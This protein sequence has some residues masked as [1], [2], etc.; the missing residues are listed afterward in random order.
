[1]LS[2]VSTA[3]NTYHWLFSPW[4]KVSNKV[5]SESSPPPTPHL[6][7]SPPTSTKSAPADLTD[8]LKHSLGSSVPFLKEIFLDF[9]AFL[10]KN[11]WITWTGPP[12]RFFTV[13][14]LE[15]MTV[16]NDVVWSSIP[17]PPPISLARPPNT[18]NTVTIDATAL[19][20]KYHSE[21]LQQQPSQ[22][23]EAIEVE[24]K[25]S[26]ELQ[27]LQT[28]FIL[29]PPLVLTEP[30][31]TP[32]LVSMHLDSLAYGQHEIGPLSEFYVLTTSC[33]LIAAGVAI[34]GILSVSNSVSAFETNL[35]HEENQEIDPQVLA[36]T[37][38]LYSKWHFSE[39]RAVFTR[40]HLLRHVELEIFLTTRS[41][42]FR[43]QRHSSIDF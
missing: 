31:H 17:S 8:L 15:L 9:E 2:R 6:L 4:N 25:S 14:T 22:D 34:H 24:R 3:C 16:D 30:A 23:S 35:S 33:Q 28:S 39:I 36:Y 19:N 43:G 32:G 5:T 27:P 13:W 42:I 26:A 40:R 21:P 41:K 18:A 20:L 10:G 1:M 7:P 29:S 12:V 11:T 38:N 37:A